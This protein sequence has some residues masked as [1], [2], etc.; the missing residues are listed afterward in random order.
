MTVYVPDAPQVS[1]LDHT[2]QNL[3]DQVWK[4]WKSKL[5]RNIERLIYLDG[6]NKL[7]DLQVSIPPTLRD[8][9]E[10]VSGW[11][12]KAVSEPANRT[13][14]DGMLTEDGNDDPFGLSEI[15]HANSFR[16]E[17]PQGI[18]ASMSYSCSFLSTTPGDVLSGDPKVLQMFHS[19]MWASG[20]L[21]RRRRA[22]SVG[23]LINAVDAIGQPTQFTMLLPFE[24]VIC[25][26]GAS[27][28]V[29]SVQRNGIGRVP[30]EVLPLGPE[31]D[32]PFGRSRIDRRVMSL[33]DRAVR[34]GSRLEV[35]SELYSAMKLILLGADQSAFQDEQGNTVPLWSWYMGRFNALE[36]NEE[37]EKPTIEKISAESPEPHIATMRQL[38]SEFSGH[39]GVPLGSL[40]IAQDQPESVDAKNVAREDIVFM[41]ERQHD[42]YGHAMIRS[43]ENTVM[44][45]D[46]LA[47]PPAEFARIE[48][49]WRRPDR[50]SQASIADAGAK[51]VAAA[52]LEGTEV[53]MRMIG[54]SN[55][56]V[57]Q[58]IA[59]LKRRDAG[60][61][62]DR[63]A[64]QQDPL[65]EGVSDLDALVKE[66]AAI[67]A[68]LDAVGVGVRAGADPDDVATRVGL[69]GLKF[70]G[71]TPVSLRQP[72]D[73]ASE[74]EDR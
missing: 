46:R 5:P 16:V 14:W 33:V 67:K 11:A 30:L 21:D 28:Y 23:L 20:L 74:L 73:E 31:L 22:L 37:G 32:R 34:G 6:K 4:Q 7:K 38:A 8:R 26:K 60:S 17:L 72:R 50:A 1:G 35:H 12:E 49:M 3:L 69:D 42:V 54:M 29:Q 61:V 47:E 44:L 27:W 18:R 65:G 56:R 51:Q 24:T 9:L 48:M 68:Q 53:G 58:A 2:T 70:T 59:E 15:L 40:G 36:N 64:P 57:R 10:V 63:L 55:S 45:R 52:K 13:V 66:S 25:V 39:T 62:L 19:A 41:V 71:A 43:F